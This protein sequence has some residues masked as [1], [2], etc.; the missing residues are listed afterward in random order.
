ME[1]GP[2][3]PDVL[4][5]LADWGSTNGAF[6]RNRVDVR[7]KVLAAVMVASGVS[8]RETARLL[9]GMSFIA[10]RDSYIRLTGILPSEERVPRRVVA[11]DE[12]VA[13]VAGRPAYLWL[14]R[15]VD[16]GKTLTFRY[17]PTGSP[18]DSAEFAR[19][20]LALCTNKPA[21]RLGR[22]PNRPRALKNL[23]FYF[24]METP[25][26]VVQRVRRFFGARSR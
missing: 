19:A 4:D 20:V 13:K 2:L 15:D 12:S 8:Y 22:G 16:S 10:A 25:P 3:V 7:R 9:G 14:A 1:D 17:S 24:A 11:L 21:A 6:L 18:E 5:I 26:G 23:D